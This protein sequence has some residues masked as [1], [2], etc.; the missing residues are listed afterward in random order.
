MKETKV[1]KDSGKEPSGK[2]PKRKI[3]EEKGVMFGM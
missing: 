2:E 1:D 3:V